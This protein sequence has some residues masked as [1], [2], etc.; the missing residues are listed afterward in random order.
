MRQ[1]STFEGCV[2]S[3]EDDSSCMEHVVD[4][5]TGEYLNILEN[6]QYNLIY[7][8]DIRWS[9]ISGVFDDDHQI[10]DIEIIDAEWSRNEVTEDG[11][12]ASKTVIW[13]DITQNSNMCGFDQITALSQAAV[14]THYRS[15]WTE[16]KATTSSFVAETMLARWNYQQCFEG[17]FKPL[18]VRLRSDGRAMV[19]VNLQEGFLTP[20]RNWAPPSADA[21]YV[22]F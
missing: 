21:K 15:I 5:I 4:F 17:T 1:F 12:A 8:H 11:R 9:K 13:R 7:H 19:F 10:D 16:A 14:N 22:S 3:N 2:E 20:L 18:T 6:A